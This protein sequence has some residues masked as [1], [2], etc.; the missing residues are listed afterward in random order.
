MP[1]GLKSG[2]WFEINFMAAIFWL[3]NGFP[4]ARGI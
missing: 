3:L 4:G 2:T 1:V